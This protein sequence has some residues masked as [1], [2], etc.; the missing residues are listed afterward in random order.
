MTNAT[1]DADE[2]HHHAYVTSDRIRRH[3]RDTD[4]NA[5]AIRCHDQRRRRA[6]RMPR[7]R[8]EQPQSVAE[9]PGSGD[10]A[11]RIKGHHPRILKFSLNLG[12]RLKGVRWQVY[13][14]EAQMISML[15]HVGERDDAGPALRSVEPV[16]GPGISADV[17]LALIP[18]VD[19]VEA[20]VKNRN[21]DEEQFQ[22]KNKWQTVQEL[23]LV[24][25]G[26]WAFEGFGIRDEVFE[27]K[28]S[29]GYDATERNADGAAGT[30][31]PRRRGGERLLI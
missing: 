31:F 1:A 20:V 6:P 28:G 22:K 25:I 17:G 19:A 5:D 13:A 27:K 8:G 12:E 21:P 26:L 2:P 23:D 24:T 29:D 4:A 3:T 18:N 16:A 7:Q 11:D 10:D 9:M 30:R 15:H 14:G